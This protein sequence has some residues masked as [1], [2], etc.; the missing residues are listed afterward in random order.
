[1]KEQSTFYVTNAQQLAVLTSHHDNSPFARSNNEH[2]NSWSTDLQ[3]IRYKRTVA[4]HATADFSPV[5]KA[6]EQK[7]H[8]QDKE[9]HRKMEVKTVNTSVGRLLL[10]RPGY[11]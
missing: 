7:Y 9:S 11:Q 6:S 1:V 5:V 4:D 3:R 8:H 10:F 2:I